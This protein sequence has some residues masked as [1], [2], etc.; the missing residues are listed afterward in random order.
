MKKF[1]HIKYYPVIPVA[2]VS[3][4]VMVLCTTFSLRASAQTLNG[5]EDFIEKNDTQIDISTDSL[6]QQY[7]EDGRKF[8][9]KEIPTPYIDDTVEI[10]ITARPND[11]YSTVDFYKRK[12]ESVKISISFN[13]DNKDIKAGLYTPDGSV[14]VVSTSGI[15][16][17]FDID[18]DGYYAVFIEN[19]SD[20]D[21][22]IV[23]FAHIN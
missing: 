2:I 19:I 5:Y 12:G 17:T 10:N 14:Y 22:S 21:V 18:E 20:T 13:P 23:G 15:N 9:D 11:V 1:I 3:I 16:H 4:F 8:S 6:H 7:S